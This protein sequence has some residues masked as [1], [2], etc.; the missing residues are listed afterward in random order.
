MIGDHEKEREREGPQMQQQQQQQQQCEAR[1][2]GSP[3]L[4]CV[5]LFAKL[6]IAQRGLGSAVAAMN[7]SLSP[8][9]ES[10]VIAQSLRN[11]QRSPV[12]CSFLFLLF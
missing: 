9:Q 6:L 4:C 1:I 8:A 12:V 11:G 7:W 10:K 5:V 2:T 3:L